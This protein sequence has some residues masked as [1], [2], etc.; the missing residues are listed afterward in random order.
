MLNLSICSA[1]KGREIAG[2]MGGKSKEFRTY[3]MELA[4]P[5]CY[6]KVKVQDLQLPLRKA[7]DGQ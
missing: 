7:K 2:E 3:L 5:L 4:L 1:N 6:Q